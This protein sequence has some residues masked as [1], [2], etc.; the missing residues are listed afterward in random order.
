MYLIL[1]HPGEPLTRPQ[2]EHL[3]FPA[4][5]QQSPEPL[6]NPHLVQSFT[7]ASAPLG[8]E[9]HPGAPLTSLHAEQSFCP[10]LQHRSEP[11]SCPHVIQI[12]ASQVWALLQVLSAFTTFGWPW[13]SEPDSHPLTKLAANKP[14]INSNLIQRM[15]ISCS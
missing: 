5:L 7:S 8:S 9:Q 4:V 1:Q 3:F 10:G 13:G 14:T 12:A 15:S 6:I 2:L 11:F